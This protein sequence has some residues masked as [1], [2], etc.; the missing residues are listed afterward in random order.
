MTVKQ[1]QTSENMGNDKSDTHT[2]RSI[3]IVTGLSGAGKSSA[4]T[5][6]EDT[7]YHTVDNLPLNM[8]T[9]LVDMDGG[10]EKALP[11]AVGIDSRALH[12][13]PK[14]FEAIV[15]T[16][17]CRNDLAVHILFLDASDDVLIKRFSETRRRH[18][19]TSGHNL[20][21]AIK[22]ERVTMSAV[23]PLVDGIL[24]TSTRNSTDTRRII[25]KRFSGKH[26]PG[27]VITFMSFGYAAGVP[28]DADLVF[29]V[30]FLRNPHYD[31]KLRNQ[32]GRDKAVANYVR[33]DI[34]Y[35][36]FMAKLIDML[37]FLLP[38]YREEGKSY[39]TLAFGCTGGRHRSVAV[40]E[41]VAQKIAL[42]GIAVNLFH[43]DTV[44]E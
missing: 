33:A 13:S 18:P 39:L 3:V 32:T 10:D 23:R 20:R 19:L 25:Q 4:L 7:G 22:S 35:N 37:E 21:A 5:A 42:D 2:P 31:D 30:R 38:R 6:F 9:S 14:G 1:S 27:L 34:G 24:D 26:S 40:A 16:L 36:D 8:L 44:L 41:A 17:R 12:F 15:K 11:L 43:R 29:D 28:R